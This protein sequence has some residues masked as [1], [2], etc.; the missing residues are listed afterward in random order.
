MGWSLY[1]LRREWNAQKEVQ[2]PWWRENSKEACSSGLSALALALRNWSESRQGKRAGRRI[3]FPRFRKRGHPMRCRFTTGTIRIDDERHITLPR[4]GRVRTCEV[5]SALGE[6]LGAGTA[7]ILSATV[8][9]EAGRWFVSFGCEVKREIPAGNGHTDTVGID[10]GVEALATLSTG[11]VVRGPRA[12]RSVLR[13]LRRLSRQHS[14]CRKGSANRRK[15]ARRLARHHARVANLRRDHLHQLTTRLAKSHGRIVV[16]DLNVAGMTRSARGTLEK[17]GGHVRA[18]SGLNRGIA[19]AGFG[20]LRRQLEYKCRWYGAELVIADRF[21]P[22]SK[23]CSR[24]GTVRAGLQ[25]SERVF[26][27]PE[28]GLRIERDF[29]AAINLAAWS[30]PDLLPHVS[31]PAAGRP[32]APHV[33]AS[34]SETENA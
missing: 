4:I 3:G 19:D 13:K 10:L 26:V 34:A 6:R 29:N 16:E 28:C 32:G 8:S 18:K 30:H 12:L 25:L 9:S 24:C 15:A 33:A 23:T 20:E 14:R 21:F 5:T 7:R 1:A 17:P 22:S 31:P 11:E 27:C 2:A